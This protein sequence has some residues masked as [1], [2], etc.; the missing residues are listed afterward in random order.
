MQ[1]IRFEPKR[2]YAENEILSN[3]NLDIWSNYYPEQTHFSGQHDQ[4]FY[5]VITAKKDNSAEKLK[6]EDIQI[7]VYNYI[8][9]Q[10]IAQAKLLAN[11]K[12][13]Q[14]MKLDRE[15]TKIFSVY[16]TVNEFIY[17][18]SFDVDLENYPIKS[19]EISHIKQKKDSL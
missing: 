16:V 1:E 15:S 8:H 17:K 14:A 3:K 13:I 7:R 2:E 9:F 4:F 5:Q 11:I 12:D 19:F 10:E 6:K 18:V